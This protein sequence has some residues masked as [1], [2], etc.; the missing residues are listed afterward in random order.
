MSNKIFF[1]E[2]IPL[3]IP[4]IFIPALLI[5]IF[6]PT[7]FLNFSGLVVMIL[8]K[9]ISYMV[10]FSKRSVCCF[11]K[12]LGISKTSLL[13]HSLRLVAFIYSSDS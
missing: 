8:S 9:E 5:E 6:T 2:I 7:L 12:S 13:I 10:R 11:I 1:P 4:L 3:Y